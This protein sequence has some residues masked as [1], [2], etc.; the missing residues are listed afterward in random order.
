[1]S[2]RRFDFKKLGRSAPGALLEALEDRRLLSGSTI[3]PVAEPSIAGNP[4]D[5]TLA[6][7]TSTPPSTAFSP[8]QIKSAYGISSIKLNGIVGDGTGQTIAIVSAYDDPNLVSSSSSAFSTSDLHLFDKEYGLADP[9]AFTKVEQT[10]AGISPQPDTGWAEEDSLD[11]EWAHAIAPG[12]KIVLLEANNAGAVQLIDWG[13]QTA[14][15][16]AGVSVI[17]MSWGFGEFNG[18]NSYDSAFTTP[19]GHEGVTFVASTGDTAAPADYPAFSPNVVAV[20]GTHLTLSGTSYSGETGYISGGGGISAYESKPSYQSSVKQ[21]SGFRTTPDVSFDG[22]PNTGVAVYDSYN[23]GHP[24]WYKI[25]GTSLGGPVWSALIAIADQGRVS[26][27]L[28]TLD[29]PTQTL[30]KLYSIASTDY[31]DI[32][33]GNNGFSAA[34]GYDLVTG[35]GSPIANVLEPD[36]AGVSASAAVITGSASITGTVFADAN[37][38]AKLDTGEAGL[39]GVK[40]YIDTNKNGV[41]D[42]GE[43]TCTTSSA[44]IYTFSK[45]PAGTYQIR[46]VLPS[47]YKLTTPTTGYLNITV[48]NGAAIKSENWGNA[49]VPVTTSYLGSISGYV[50][51]D[52]NSNGKLDSTEKG[53]A[54]ITVF[55]DTNGDGKL[56]NGEVSTTT[57]ASGYYY[58][59]ISTAATYRIAEVIP[60]GYHLTAPTVDYY[61]VVVKGGWNVGN[62]DF[63]NLK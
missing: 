26:A 3:D 30:P 56:D 22:D 50:Y 58:F 18:E 37:S 24:G 53:L 35:R 27:G 60:S 46:E 40:I 16:M 47:G 11:V 33:S 9:P 7:G 55:I 62:E 44:G 34:S 31:H 6:D 52:T 63:G 42:T 48:A 17:D 10:S 61:L 36:L 43:T 28:T 19:S 4:L 15:N 59:G 12:A 13:V 32:T 20:G 25:A 2:K 41:L 39:S 57:N 38:N 5:G 14:E 1:M 29:G 54:G 23:G 8:S 21:S 51:T 45:L 49:R